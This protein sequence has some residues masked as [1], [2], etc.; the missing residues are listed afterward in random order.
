[1]SVSSP[2]GRCRR[3]RSKVPAARR[4]GGRAGEPRAP[5][6]ARTTRGARG[7]LDEKMCIVT[8][9]GGGIGRA[10]AV[11]MG[12][13]APRGH[14][15]RHRRRGT[16]RR[17]QAGEATGGTRRS[18]SHC[19]VEDADEIV[20]LIDGTVA[21]RRPGRPAQ[22]RRRPGDRLR[23]GPAVDTLP[24]EVWDKVYGSTCAPSGWPPSTRRRTCAARSAT[25]RS[26]MLLDRRPR[27]LSECPVYNA[28]KGAILMLT[29]STAVDL[30][31]DVRCNCYCPGAV[32]T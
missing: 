30:A 24:M 17:R 25:P 26:S 22:Q 2:N 27:R 23:H 32:D 1:M 19:D 12:A 29:K 14:G 20:A 18:T 4:A 9:S 13:R 16:A 10:T 7:M 28:T 5:L 3:P 15:D 31:P 8:G 6:S 21:V 11:E